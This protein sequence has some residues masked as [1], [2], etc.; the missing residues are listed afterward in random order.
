MVSFRAYLEDREFHL[1]KEKVHQQVDLLV[2][3][4]QFIGNKLRRLFLVESIVDSVKVTFV[5]PAFNL[6]TDSQMLEI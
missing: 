4:V 6:I 3:H 1:P 2:E 5:F